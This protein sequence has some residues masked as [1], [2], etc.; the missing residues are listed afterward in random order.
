MRDS[1]E[2]LDL[3]PQHEADEPPG[4]S[5]EIKCKELDQPQRVEDEQEALELSHSPDE[6]NTTADAQTEHVQQSD[7]R[8]KKEEPSDYVNIST[9]KKREIPESSNTKKQECSIQVILHRF[10]YKYV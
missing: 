4:G 9:H 10:T 3:T 2:E 6:K 5:Q 1:E 7:S 8:N